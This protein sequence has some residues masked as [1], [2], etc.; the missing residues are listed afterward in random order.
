MD[1]GKIQYVDTASRE[2]SKGTR[3]TLTEDRVIRRM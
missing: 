2:F 3:V 1:N